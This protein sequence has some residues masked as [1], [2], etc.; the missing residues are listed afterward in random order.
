MHCDIVHI[1]FRLLRGIGNGQ[2]SKLLMTELQG[3]SHVPKNGK[4]EVQKSIIFR[5][6]LNSRENATVSESDA[7]SVIGV[8]K[9]FN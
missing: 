6:G 8:A 7:S 3:F 9:L 4:F 2:G 5:E 1:L